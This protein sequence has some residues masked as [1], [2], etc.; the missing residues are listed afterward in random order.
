MARDAIIRKYYDEGLF[1]AFVKIIQTD[2]NEAENT[3]DI[4]FLIDEGEDILIKKIHVLGAYNVD[5][6][7]I[8]DALELKED[9]LI[10]DG[11]FKEVTFEKDKQTIIDFYKERGYLDVELADSRW[12]IKWENAKD[13]EERIIHLTYQKQEGE[14]Y[15]FNGYDTEHDRRFLSPT[16]NK[17]VKDPKDLQPVYTLKHS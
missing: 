16:L 2:K 9:G 11:T 6:E 3:A 13:Q 7:D 5:P 1:L 15:F 14:K 17:D 12:D 4:V 10:D 8:L